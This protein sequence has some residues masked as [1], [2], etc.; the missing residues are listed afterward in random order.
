MLA[1]LLASAAALVAF[2]V[3]NSRDGSNAAD[4]Q[5][6]P[7]VAPTTAVL[8]AKASIPINTAITADLLEVRQVL[9]DQV[10]P[11]ALTSLDQA[12]GKWSNIALL[13][14]EQIHAGS[15][16]DDQGTP[17][18]LAYKVPI[19]KRA[20]SIVFD[21]VMG[22]G[23]LVQPGDHVD[24]IGY[25]VVALQAPKRSNAAGE[26]EPAFVV[27]TEGATM[28]EQPDKDSDV[29]TE[30]DPDAEISVLGAEGRYFR[31]QAGDQT[32]W[33]DA[34]SIVVKE[35]AGDPDEGSM[36]YEDIAESH[37]ATYIVQN[38]EVLAVSQAV[39][40]EESGVTQPGATVGDSETGTDTGS[41]TAPAATDSA[42]AR[43]TARSVTLAVTPEEAQRLLLAAQSTS[44]KQTDRNIGVRLV[45]R[46]PGDTTI[47]DLPPAELGPLPVGNALSG[48]NQPLFPSDLMITDVEFTQRVVNAGQVLEFKATI[49]NVSD[50]TVRGAKTAPP[51]FTYPEGTAYDTLGFD[52]ELDTYRIGL[53]LS[54]AYPTQF[55]YRWGIGRD[56]EP[57]ETTTVVGYVQLTDPTVATTYW[58]GMIHEP[59]IVTQDGV[60]VAD[61]TVLTPEKVAVNQAGAAMLADARSGANLVATLKPGQILEVIQA[62]GDWFRVKTGQF[63]GWIQMSAVDVPSPGSEPAVT[64]GLDLNRLNPWAKQENG[65]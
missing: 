45:V 53:N 29:I 3:V 49:K 23:G 10:Q 14:G 42:V 11:D 17:A 31:V 47:A 27:G 63:E 65:R 18:G 7:T 59:E 43:P 35:G 33:I 36:K 25:F 2:M 64:G 38:I 20:I 28:L 52:A 54:N 24:V 61:V 60:G 51:E 62:R 6:A 1:L 46:A 40:P 9:P 55:P 58:F 48:V 12:V 32:G 30:L 21:E 44:D 26:S 37:V 57:G 5:A 50:H 39:S 22:T 16:T 56:L 4:S 13:P 15:V 41:G 8:I 34:N 19:G